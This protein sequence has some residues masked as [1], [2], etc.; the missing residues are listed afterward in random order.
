MSISNQRI[1][2]QN[3]IENEALGSTVDFRVQSAVWLA[4]GL[5]GSTSLHNMKYFGCSSITS[6][7]LLAREYVLSYQ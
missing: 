6:D 4:K 3:Y 1:V 5:L 2:N 7:I